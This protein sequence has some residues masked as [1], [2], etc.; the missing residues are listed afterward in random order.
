VDIEDAWYIVNGYIARYFERK[1]SKSF[2][3]SV[4]EVDFIFRFSGTALNDARRRYSTGIGYNL[5]ESMRPKG[6]IKLLTKLTR[7][8]TTCLS[9]PF[10]RV[11]FLS[12]NTTTSKSAYSYNIACEMYSQ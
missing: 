3:W 7:E 4:Y 8:T 1:E 5:Y 2:P 12:N 10:V 11:S 6:S 9:V